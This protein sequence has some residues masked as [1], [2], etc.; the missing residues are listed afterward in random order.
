MTD[1]FKRI[2]SEQRDDIA[3]LVVGTGIVTTGITAGSVQEIYNLPAAAAYAPAVTTG[4]M[5]GGASLG[6]TFF[7]AT[8]GITMVGY[9]L[10]S[11][12]GLSFSEEE[13]NKL[14]QIPVKVGAIGA[15]MGAGVGG[16]IGAVGVSIGRYVAESQYSETVIDVMEKLQ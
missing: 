2:I 1:R 12:V 4:A 14:F 8:M 11:I 16:V 10:A 5:I 3:A 13:S 7:G 6:L 9:V 15:A